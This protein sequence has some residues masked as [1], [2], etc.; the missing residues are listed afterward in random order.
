MPD[1]QSD[2]SAQWDHF[3]PSKDE[4]IDR[5]IHWAGN[6]ATQQSANV[7]RDIHRHVEWQSMAQ[8]VYT[9][10][11]DWQVKAGRGWWRWGT[12]YEAGTFDQELYILP[13][14]DPLS[15]L[16]DPDAKQKSGLDATKCLIF[17]DVPKDDFYGAYPELPAGEPRQCPAGRDHDL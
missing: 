10:A 17:D 14:L 11:R 15:V 9:L 1:D 8:D 5:K 6:G 16:F 3:E 2:S 13:V 7:F 12:E 4:Q